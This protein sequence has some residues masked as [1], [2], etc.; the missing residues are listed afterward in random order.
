MYSMYSMHCVYS[1]QCTV[2]LGKCAGSGVMLVVKGPA[3]LHGGAENSAVHDVLPGDGAHLLHHPPAGL[4]EVNTIKS[5]F[6][7]VE[8]FP[9]F[10]MFS[11][12]VR[13]Y[14]NI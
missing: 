3:L 4:S 8:I 14:R 5:Y 7:F 11:E 9:Y 6:E 13:K 1:A 2:Y 12:F 10:Q